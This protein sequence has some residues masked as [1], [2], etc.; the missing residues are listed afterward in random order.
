MQN[1]LSFNKWLI[2]LKSTTATIVAFL[3]LFEVFI[4]SN[5]AKRMLNEE[6]VRVSCSGGAIKLKYG[7]RNMQ[8]GP[9]IF[10]L[11]RC[12]NFIVQNPAVML[13]PF[14]YIYVA[15]KLFGFL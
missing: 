3:L 7:C 10:D 13:P 8:F 6:A 1:S 12:S 2:W 4:V 9:S 5:E 11:K 15:A 14:G